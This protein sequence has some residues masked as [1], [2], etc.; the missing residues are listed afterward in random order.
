LSGAHKLFTYLRISK[1]GKLLK[2]DAAVNNFG[3]KSMNFQQQDQFYQMM[4]NSR[5]R[6][7]A[8]SIPRITEMSGGV[9]ISRY[10]MPQEEK[11]PEVI[12]L[13]E[14]AAKQNQSR[15]AN[16]V[17]VQENNNNKL[18]VIHNFIRSNGRRI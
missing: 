12:D 17:S 14:Y 1:S 15:S 10:A 4:T 8:A 13:Q 2:Y 9:L 3:T 6:S 5:L 18:R 7:K 11:E 16:N